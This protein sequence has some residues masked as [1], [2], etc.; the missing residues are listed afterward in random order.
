MERTAVNP[1]SRCTALRGCCCTSEGKCLSPQYEQYDEQCPAA[2]WPPEMDCRPHSRY[3]ISI[4]KKHGDRNG[5]YVVFWRSLSTLCA[6]L[7]VYTVP[8]PS[9]YKSIIA[10]QSNVYSM[11][12][13]H[14][15][16]V[17][18]SAR[19][20]TSTPL[21]TVFLI[22][23]I[24]ISRNKLQ[25][26]QGYQRRQVTHCHELCQVC[27][28]GGGHTKCTGQPC[29]EEG[30]QKHAPIHHRHE[31]CKQRRFHTLCGCCVGV[32]WV[33]RGCV[34]CIACVQQAMTALHRY[35]THAHIGCTTTPPHPPTHPPT[36]LGTDSC[37]QHQQ[38]HK[39]HLP[40]HH[41]HD[42]I[43]NDKQ[44]IA[45]TP[46]LIKPRDEDELRHSQP[47]SQDGAVEQCF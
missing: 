34:L 26:R 4:A 46:F 41:Q 18:L 11:L 28:I 31:R 16:C 27:E 21:I 1:W 25:Q 38:R 17:A 15:C 44:L 29:P 35:S 47:H 10:Q 2:R 22:V 12:F 19:L 45:Q 30:T 3:T 36:H 24:F 8:N 39:S 14:S 32:V 33:L 43:T 13:C 7:C 23:H 6:V 9:Y 42:T 37:C 20:S 5:C 40:Q